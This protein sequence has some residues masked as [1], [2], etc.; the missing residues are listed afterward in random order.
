[1]AVPPETLAAGPPPEDVDAPTDPQTVPI[2][3]EKVRGN[4]A[5]ILIG[6][7]AAEVLLA[8]I[9]LAARLI[10]IDDLKTL[11]EVVFGPTVALVGSVIGFYFG[12][13][14]SDGGNSTP[15]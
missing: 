5:Y 8:F 9:A 15:S 12:A 1:M 11:L 4:L 13:T 3:R 10:G 6:T 7:L 2:A 14:K